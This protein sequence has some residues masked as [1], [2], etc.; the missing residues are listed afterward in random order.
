MSR[1]TDTSSL[2]L[3]AEL[4]SDLNLETLAGGE[5]LNTLDSMSLQGNSSTSLTLSNTVASHLSAT[6]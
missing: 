1:G 6:L 3:V 2:S 4:L 5:R